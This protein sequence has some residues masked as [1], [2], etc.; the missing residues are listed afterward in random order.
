[1][2]STNELIWK[3]LWFTLKVK[4]RFHMHS[5]FWHWVAAARPPT[6]APRSRDPFSYP[7]DTKRDSWL[8]KIF[9]FLWEKQKKNTM[10]GA[11][12][13][14]IL[15]LALTVFLGAVVAQPLLDEAG[16][17]TD[18]K[19]KDL[20]RHLLQTKKTMTTTLNSILVF[21]R[22]YGE[23]NHFMTLLYHPFFG[24]ILKDI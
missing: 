3:K 22:F 6:S 18:H 21:S 12:K 20:E 4:K 15:V 14:L 16:K 9:L 17:C 1:M 5:S 8:E 23:R 24:S 11:T 2:S 10:T 7:V 19:K 13:I